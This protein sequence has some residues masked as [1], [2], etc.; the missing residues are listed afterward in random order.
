MTD[1]FLLVFGCAV[2]FLALAGAW[3]FLDGRMLD[4]PV[5][6]SKKKTKKAPEATETPP[7][8]AAR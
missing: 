7:V 1:E 2:T 4:I 8:V 3:I 5:L 6:R